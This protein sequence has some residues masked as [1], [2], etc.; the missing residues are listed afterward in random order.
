[1]KYPRFL[2]AV[3]CC[4]TIAF[5]NISGCKKNRLADEE[6]SSMS[7]VVASQDHLERALSYVNSDRQLEQAEFEEQVYSNLSRW[8]ENRT[9]TGNITWTQDPL[10]ETLPKEYR[11]IQLAKLL[12]S[13]AYAYSDSQFLKQCS[14][15]KSVANRLEKQPVVNVWPPVEPIDYSVQ[16]KDNSKDALAI[17]LKTKHTDLSDAEVGKLASALRCFDWS[18]RAIQLAAT[19]GKLSEQETQEQKLVRNDK[20]MPL[21]MMG[22]LGPGYRTHPYQTMMYGTGD[23]LARARVFIGLCQQLNI[24]VVMLGIEK[25]N[26]IKPWLPAALIGKKLYLFDSLLGIAIPTPAGKI[27]T[28][29]D[30]IKDSSLLTRLN[31]TTD[32]RIVLGEMAN[33]TNTD[34]RVTKDDLENVVVLVDASP[35]QLSRRMAILENALSGNERMELTVDPTSLKQ[36]LSSNEAI[37]KV[38]LWDVPFKTVVFRNVLI[39]AI[40]AASTDN[41][42][43]VRIRRLILDE[44]VIDN[45]TLFQTAK[46]RYLQGLFDTPRGSKKYSCIRLLSDMRYTNEEIAGVAQNDWLLAALNIRQAGQS[47]QN[48]ARRIAILKGTMGRIRIDA[49]YF[50]GVANFEWGS[51]S[52]AINWFDRV[53]DFDQEGRWND[54]INYSKARCYESL[55]DYEKAISLYRQEKRKTKSRQI[56]GNLIRSRM[57]KTSETSK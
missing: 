22:I 57:L 14:W 49:A 41:E 4:S 47:A 7:T 30:V 9:D 32:E 3:I 39:Q 26:E 37:K 40:R 19:P 5:L 29:S 8:Q 43:Q 38:V 24:D 52:T 28:L 35:E 10:F 2:C 45:F 27:A 33:T 42:L 20:K 1:M 6:W 21:P 12:N 46:T 44:S 36:Q 48:F 11:E 15:L 31:L 25:D 53:V 18:T 16:T 50:L 34:Y 17:G 54:G 23:Y 55:G 51:P 56:I 13:T